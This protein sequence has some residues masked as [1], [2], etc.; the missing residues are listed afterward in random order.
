MTKQEIKH[1]LVEAIRRA[2][3]FADIR[4]VALFGSHVNQTSTEASDVDVLIDFEP[5][6]SVGFFALSDIK[7]FLET[8]LGKPVDLLTP[9]AISKYFRASVLAQAETIY[10]R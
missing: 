2:P 8:A 9:Q 7:N 3:H 5:T 4:S 6:A 1:K 10:E